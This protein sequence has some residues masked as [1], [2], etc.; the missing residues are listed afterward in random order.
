[1]TTLTAEFPTCKVPEIDWESIRRVHALEYRL[2]A[3]EQRAHA[4]RIARALQAGDYE[5]A[6][7]ALKDPV[8]KYILNPWKWK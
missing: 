2:N 8:D 1:M 4:Q 7:Q 6:F 5:G 3:E